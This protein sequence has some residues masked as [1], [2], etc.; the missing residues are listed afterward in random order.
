MLEPSKHLHPQ[1]SGGGHSRDEIARLQDDLRALLAVGMKAAAARAVEVLQPAAPDEA[2]ALLEGVKQD[3]VALQADFTAGGL[4][5]VRGAARFACDALRLFRVCPRLRCRKAQSC[6]GNPVA[7]H[8]RAEVPE[9]ARQWVARMWLAG[10]VPMLTALG[11]AD[12]GQRAAYEAWIAGI[13]AGTTR[14]KQAAPV[15]RGRLEGALDAL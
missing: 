13:E 15:S 6:R 11:A 9:P 3:L 8:T 12:A 7:C 1:A 4:P 2:R 5:A 14:T 10:Q